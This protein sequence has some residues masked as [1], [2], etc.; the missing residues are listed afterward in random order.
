VQQRGFAGTVLA[1]QHDERMGK[2]HH[3]GHVKVE[4]DEYRVGENFQIHR[5]RISEFRRRL[6]Q[7]ARVFSP[8]QMKE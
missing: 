5:F 1:L 6:T 3:H 4:I 2:I 8:L 7:L